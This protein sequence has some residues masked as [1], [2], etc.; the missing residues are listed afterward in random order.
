MEDLKLERWPVDRFSAHKRTL[1][2]NDHS[3]ERMVDS[4]REFGFKIPLL[5]RS[6][7]EIIDGHL[8]LK[9]ARK[10]GLP[11]VPVILCDEWNDAQVKA[12][13]LL[14]NRSATWAQWDWGLVALE[15]Q[16]LKE[17]DFDLALTGFDPAELNR[18]LFPSPPES[19]AGVLADS[20]VTRTGDIWICGSHRILCGDATSADDVKRLFDGHDPALMVT[21]PPY[22]VA[23]DPTWRERAGLGEQRQTG[24]VANDDRVDW[25]S[26]Y[27]L[28]PGSVAYVWHAG[29]HAGEVARGLEAAGFVIRSQIIWAKQHF[30]L[31]RGDYHWQHEPCWYAVR[32]GCSSNWS[33]DRKQATLWEVDNLNPFGGDSDEEATGHGTQKPVELMRRAILNNTRIGE[34]VYDPFLGSGTT[35]A[36]AQATERVCYGLDIDPR[37]VDLAVLRW[38]KLSERQAILESTEQAFEETKQA[39]AEISPAPDATEAA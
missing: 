24:L 4:I 28:F 17:L 3:V 33:G 14:A 26:A 15:I 2:K 8:R 31:S 37:Y 1:R 19:E 11:N 6:V 18:L 13:R 34:V 36:A 12:F 25:T 30:A 21:D 39:R 35:L 7:G 9:A 10:M 32:E 27:R 16:E 20:V 5:V 23:Y 29:I 38:Q 22:G